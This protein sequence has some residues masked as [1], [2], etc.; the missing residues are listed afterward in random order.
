M[1]QA[2]HHPPAAQACA[3]QPNGMK[4]AGIGPTAFTPQADKAGKL[5]YG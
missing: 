5:H 2:G 4:T 1:L 3:P